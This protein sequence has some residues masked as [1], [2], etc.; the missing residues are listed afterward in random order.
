MP[1][2]ISDLGPLFGRVI[3]VALGLAGIVLFVMLLLGGFRY[4]TSSG[5]PKVAEAAKKTITYA[6]GGLIV[7]LLVYLV[8]VLIK[9]L[10]GVDVTNFQIVQP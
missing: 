2:K 1:A 6:I 9:T 5:D 3:Q 10:T 4:L 8:L 7:I